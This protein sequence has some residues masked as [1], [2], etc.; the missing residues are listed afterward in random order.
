[1]AQAASLFIMDF[2]FYSKVYTYDLYLNLSVLKDY[3]IDAKLMHGWNKEKTPDLTKCFFQV[4]YYLNN[5]KSIDK[6]VNSIIADVKFNESLDELEKAE[7][8]NSLMFFCF[9]AEKE[10]RSTVFN[11]EDYSQLAEIGEQ[12]KKIQEMKPSKL[13]VSRIAINDKD[14]SLKIVEYTCDL[15]LEKFKMY[16]MFTKFKDI[17]SIDEV[18]SFADE[19]KEATEL[20]HLEILGQWA[21]IIQT[22]LHNKNY[23]KSIDNSHL[24]QNRRSEFP[25]TNEQSK[26]IYSLFEIYNFLTPRKKDSASHY[27]YIRNCIDKFLLNCNEGV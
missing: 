13:T 18:M 9:E 16:A 17:T 10:L 22:Y 21:H 19:F 4:T 27:H 23:I 12:I 11:D 26:L 3:H 8:R 15:L 2:N 20:A 1:M 5:N 14:I 7:L 6:D 25:L 24:N